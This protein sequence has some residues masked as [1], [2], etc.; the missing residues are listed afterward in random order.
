MVSTHS[1]TCARCKR[2]NPIS[3]VVEP[4]EAWK[5]VVLNRWRKLCSSCVKVWI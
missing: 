5:V 1:N 4:A 3:F 2:V